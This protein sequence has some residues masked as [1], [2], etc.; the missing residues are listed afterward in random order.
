MTEPSDAVETI[1]ENDPRYTPDRFP[2]APPADEAADDTPVTV[3]PTEPERIFGNPDDEQPT[4]A[5]TV[6]VSCTN[7]NCPERHMIQLYA[8]TPLPIHCGR[9]G[10]VLHD[11]PEGHERRRLETLERDLRTPG[12]NLDDLTKRVAK[13]IRK[14]P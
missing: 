2:A 10:T 11:T 7:P 8:D 12:L 4:A 9:C 5:P 1:F 13:H 3:A 6:T 14:K